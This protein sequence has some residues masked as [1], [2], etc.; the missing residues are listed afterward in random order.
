MLPVRRHC[1]VDPSGPV[2]DLLAIVVRPL[3]SV[4]LVVV[5]P[6]AVLARRRRDH[7]VQASAGYRSPTG[8]GGF[9]PAE[10]SSVTID[11]TAQ[12]MTL[13]GRG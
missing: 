4:L 1:L 11:F 6:V 7:L 2:R 8:P 5:W 13:A 9:V 3:V 12:Q 10:G